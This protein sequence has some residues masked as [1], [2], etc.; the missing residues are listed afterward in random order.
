[1]ATKSIHL[2]VFLLITLILSPVRSLNM[3]QQMAL[4]TRGVM[5]DAGGII[6]ARIDQIMADFNQ[7]GIHL[8]HGRSEFCSILSEDVYCYGKD[9]STREI[10]RTMPIRDLAWGFV[11]DYESTDEEDD[12]SD[13]SPFDII[14]R[15]QEIFDQHL[16]IE[17]H[18]KNSR[19][20]SNISSYTDDKTIVYC[21]MNRNSSEFIDITRVNISELQNRINSWRCINPHVGLGNGGS[22]FGFTVD[23]DDNIINGG[24]EG[25]SIVES[26]LQGA[27]PNLDSNS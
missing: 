7:S 3:H 19:E 11:K 20:M 2:S 21:A 1:M 18:F 17:V 4:D 24:L 13:S 14:S 9:N 26:C 27:I 22:A 25:P 10:E 12:G 16:C 23:G 5:E 6:N 15:D 8:P